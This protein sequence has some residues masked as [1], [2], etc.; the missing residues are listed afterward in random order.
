MNSDKIPESERTLFQH[1]G[2]SVAHIPL[3]GKFTFPFYYQP[4]PLARLAA[5]QVQRLIESTDWGHS[6]G[7]TKFGMRQTG[8]MFGVLVVQ[9]KDGTPG[10]LQAYSGQ[11]DNA[12]PGFVPFVY[13]LPE[14]DNFYTRGV[15]RVEALTDEIRRFKKDSDWAAAKNA[16]EN[17]RLETKRKIEE[18][19]QHNRSAK[20]MRAGLRENALAKGEATAEFIEAL[21]EESRQ[22]KLFLKNRSAEFMQML[23]RAEDKLKHYEEKYKALTVRRA[24]LSSNIQN[25]IFE[26]YRFLNIRGEE[27]TLRSIFSGQV[28]PSGAGDCAAPKLLQYA[29]QHGLKPIAMA[30]FWWGASPK[31]TIRHHRKFY[32]AC[33]SKCS[34]ILSHMLNGLEVETNPLLLEHGQEKSIETVYE[35]AHIAVINKPFGL[36]SVPGKQIR[37]SVLTRLR[38]KYPEA[39][40]PLLVHRLDMDTSGLML[41]AKNQKAHKILQAQFLKR[42]V[43]KMYVALL[44]GHCETSAGTIDLPLRVDLDDRPNQMVCFTHGK[45]ARTR[46]EVVWSDNNSTRIHFFPLTGRTHQLRMHAAHPLGLNCPIRGDILY[47]K[48]QDRMYLHAEML[49]FDHPVSGRR[50]KLVAKPEF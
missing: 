31:T 7:L 5:A 33:L 23:D 18:I 10:F 9:Q 14:G 50:L 8:K 16:L 19:K 21:A 35:D 34:P 26:N 45:P 22:N 37:D 12:P 28:P 24:N 4:H 39:S 30:E 2:Q 44:D 43:E 20:N 41:V 40:G 32:P 17:L 38:T 25:R 47:G 29:F 46:Y 42:S 27:R 3:P 6:F 1:F 36:L 49:A 15:E 48:E 13:A 11:L